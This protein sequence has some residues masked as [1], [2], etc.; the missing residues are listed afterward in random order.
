MNPAPFP[1]NTEQLQHLIPS[2][3]PDGT[4]PDAP[5]CQNNFAVKGIIHGRIALMDTLV[6]GQMKP[7]DKLQSADTARSLLELTAILSHESATNLPET[8]AGQA[9]PLGLLVS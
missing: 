3:I 6:R 1:P 4:L 8:P 9:D 5:D 7:K 2:P